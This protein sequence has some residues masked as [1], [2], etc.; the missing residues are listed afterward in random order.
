MEAMRL[1]RCLRCDSAGTVDDD[2]V[3]RIVQRHLEETYLTVPLND[4]KKGSEIQVEIQ[5]QGT[6][7]PSS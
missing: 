3:H 2:V 1:G 4:R 6:V 5:A 7:V